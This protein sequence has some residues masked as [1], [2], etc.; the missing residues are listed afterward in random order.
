MYSRLICSLSVYFCGARI[1]FITIIKYGMFSGV[2]EQFATLH[3]KNCAI[4]FY[5]E[6]YFAHNKQ[7]VLF[8]RFQ[9]FP[10]QRSSSQIMHAQP[11]YVIVH[12][13]GEFSLDATFLGKQGLFYSVTGKF[14]DTVQIFNEIINTCTFIYFIQ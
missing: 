5:Y 2:I 7:Q 8:D 4:D 14:S 11:F 10:Q 1:C 12:F 6:L 9:S 3:C 13:S